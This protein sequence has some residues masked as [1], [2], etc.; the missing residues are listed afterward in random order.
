MSRSAGNRDPS[1]FVWFD[2][3]VNKHAASLADVGPKS[4]RPLV[5]L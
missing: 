3:C 4:L 1:L 5:K 2:G